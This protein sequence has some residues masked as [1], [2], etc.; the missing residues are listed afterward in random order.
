MEMMGIKNDQLQSMMKSIGEKLTLAN[1]I[2][3]LFQPV[4]VVFVISMGMMFLD[5]LSTSITVDNGFGEALRCSMQDGQQCC[6]MID[7]V[8]ICFEKFNAQVGTDAFFNYFT[9]AITNIIGVMLLWFM[10]F[11]VMK[12]SKIT[13][14]AVNKIQ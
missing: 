13:E 10:V 5:T 2:N 3:L 6:S 11:A 8:N 14:S 12:S 1:V 7:V 9:F 4:L